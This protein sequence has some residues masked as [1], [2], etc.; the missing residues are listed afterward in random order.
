MVFGLIRKIRARRATKKARAMAS[1]TKGRITTAKRAATKRK[2]TTRTSSAKRRTTTRRT[3]AKR[4][5]S[6][7]RRTKKRR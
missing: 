2:T 1:K 5:A 7:N 3:T 6:T 4:T